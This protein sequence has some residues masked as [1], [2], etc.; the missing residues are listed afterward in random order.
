MT[1]EEKKTKTRRMRVG[2]FYAYRFFNDF[3]LLYPLYAVMFADRGLSPA[4]ISILLAVWS[5]TRFVFEVPSGALADR[6]SRKYLLCA[7]QLVQILG[8]GI[9][10]LWPTFTGFLLGFICWGIKS[11][12]M[13]GTFEAALY[14]AL[15]E[16]KQEGLFAKIWGRIGSIGSAAR[17]LA[18]LGA[19]V[20]IIFGYPFI[21]IG[22]IASLVLSAILV[23]FLPSAPHRTRTRQKKYLH[24]LR[25]GL[26]ISFRDSQ[27]VR[28]MVFASMVLG[29]F[30]ALE[31]YWPL[32]INAH[33]GLP[34]PAL[35]L[36]LAV[37]T[38]GDALA[39]SLAHR[40]RK[41]K[42]RTLYSV[43]V[44]IGLLQA[45]AAV[46]GT[47]W[48]LLGLLIVSGLGTA[49]LVVLDTQFQ[50]AIPTP[51]RATISSVRG[52]MGET[53]ILMAYGLFGLFAGA[54]AYK[55]AMLAAGFLMAGVGVVCVLVER[56]SQTKHVS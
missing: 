25:E 32:F 46:A 51:I 35:G 28:L 10:L 43:F 21:V 54:Y 42:P 48:N 20:G 11:A 40:I 2:S 19:S 8:F 23:L 37:L 15:A 9:W 27:I 34:K 1:R 7:G 26:S 55:H 13:S 17:V 50:D 4:K 33:A 56:F 47:P 14:D 49:M 39:S 41:A 24:L 31:E 44:I 38:T 6:Y 53:G 36:V 12:F 5:V 29:F 52:L 22:S 30:G 45:V 18:M 3:I 16:K